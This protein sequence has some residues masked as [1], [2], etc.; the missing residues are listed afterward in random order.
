MSRIRAKETK[1]GKVKGSLRT[2]DNDTD[3]SLIAQKMG[4]GGHKKAAGFA[5]EGTIEG[6]LDIVLTVI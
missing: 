2:T 3:V 4:G 6:V 1:D 5:V